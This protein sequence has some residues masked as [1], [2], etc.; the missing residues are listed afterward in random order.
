MTDST[1]TLPR[2]ISRSE[3]NNTNNVLITLKKRGKK[4]SPSNL[5]IRVEKYDRDMKR[6][7]FMDEEG[8]RDQHKI[9]IKQIQAQSGRANKGGA[10]FNILNLQYENSQDGQ[11][12]MQK[13]QDKKARDM[14]RSMHVDMRGNSNYN[15]LNGNDRQ[16]INVP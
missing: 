11:V 9:Q 3:S 13:D 16:Q 4:I 14:L 1:V 12:L 10:A 5:L 15:L 7:E 6:W 2:M 8:A